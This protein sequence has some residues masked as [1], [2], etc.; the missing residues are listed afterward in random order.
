MAY[1]CRFQ[2][3]RTRD[4][5]SIAGV[6]EL[7]NRII[8]AEQTYFGHPWGSTMIITTKCAY[9]NYNRH[10]KTKDSEIITSYKW[11]QRISGTKSVALNQ[12]TKKM[13]TMKIDV[14]QA[15]SECH[16]SLTVFNS[17]I[18]FR[19]RFCEASDTHPYCEFQR[20]LLL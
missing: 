16:S 11:L 10:L 4:D 7:R 13:A 19:R 9:F 8:V 1:L 12:Q 18:H 5:E 14:I 3:Q 17:R 20:P 2:C 6:H 15:G